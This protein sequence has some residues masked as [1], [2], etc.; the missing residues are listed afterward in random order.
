[1]IIV[2]RYGYGRGSNPHQTK[3]YNKYLRRHSGREIA[4]TTW[5]RAKGQR[6]I[7]TLK[8]G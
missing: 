7:T 3:D 5:I 8:K 6:N 4:I 2:V 1:M